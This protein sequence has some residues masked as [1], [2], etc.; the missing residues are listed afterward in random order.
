MSRDFEIQDNQVYRRVSVTKNNK[1]IPAGI[2]FV[3]GISLILH[4]NVK[5]TI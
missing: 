4:E 3:L 2:L 1:Q 5:K